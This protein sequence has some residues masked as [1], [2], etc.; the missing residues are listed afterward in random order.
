VGVSTDSEGKVFATVSEKGE[1]RVFD[2]VNFGESAEV[3]KRVSWF[4]MMNG[5]DMINIL[6]LDYTP[7]TCCWVHHPS[8]GRTLLAM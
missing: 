5:A 6:K 3:I 8:D 2:V 4:L 1:G 7:K